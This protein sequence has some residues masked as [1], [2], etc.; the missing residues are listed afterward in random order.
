[1][2]VCRP[3]PL[4]SIATLTARRSPSHPS[5]MCLRTPFHGKAKVVLE[6]GRTSGALAQNQGE[7]L[8]TAIV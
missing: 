2:T 4:T 8:R 5:T 1:V 7:Q 3:G 6:P